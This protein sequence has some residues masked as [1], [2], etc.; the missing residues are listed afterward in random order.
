MTTTTTV[1]S[2]LESAL[3]PLSF[4]L[5]NALA[6]TEGVAASSVATAKSLLEQVSTQVLSQYDKEIGEFNDLIDEL[7]V[8]RQAL[9]TALLSA[10]SSKATIAQLEV[11]LE[12]K[13]AQLAK[14]DAKMRLDNS[15]HANLRAELKELQALDPQRMKKNL[16]DVKTKLAEATRMRD[17]L[18]RDNLTLRREKAQLQSRAAELVT[19][20]LKLTEECEELRSR[21]MK[22]D[23]DVNDRYFYTDYQGTKVGYYIYV[24][25]FGLDISQSDPDIRLINKELHWHMEV[26][27][28]LGVSII[29]SVTDW[30]TPFYPDPTVNPL[31]AAWPDDLNDEVVRK[32]RDLCADTHPMQL[33]RSEWAELQLLSELGLPEKQ[34]NL[35]AAANIKTLFDVARLSPGGLTRAKGIGEKTARE[36]HAFCMKHVREW[37]ADYERDMRKHAA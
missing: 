37:Q 23:G 17:D 18:N 12:E 21:L 14:L 26:R 34:C 2:A 31:H 1:A 27:S 16:A 13:S 29:V 36:I 5:D 24:F 7:E 35:L 20:T 22:M 15:A 9:E 3:R 30:L 33:A 8:C 28:T 11:E 25:G 4:Q 32:I 10:G 19:A 6:V